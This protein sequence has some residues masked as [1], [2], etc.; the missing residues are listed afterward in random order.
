MDSEVEGRGRQSSAVEGMPRRIIRG[1]YVVTDPSGLPARGMVEDAGVL[2]A[3]DKVEEVAEWRALR[4]RCPDVEVFGSERHLVLPG[5]VNA[6]HHGRGLSG[7]QLGIPDDFLERWLLDYW[8]MPPLDVHLDT[9]YSNL[10]MIRSGVT[11]VIHSSYAR[12]WGRIEA[13]TRDAL[14]AYAEAGIRVA[15]AVGFEDRVRLVFGDQAAF[16]ASLPGDLAVRARELVQPVSETETE[17]YFAFVS[18]LHEQHSAN[19]ALEILHG[20]SWHVWCSRDLLERVAEDARNRN[21]GIHLHVLESPLEREY[22]LRAYGMDCVSYLKALGIRGPRVSFA[23]G[24]WL[25]ESEIEQCAESGVSICH[26]PS[27]NLRLRNGI[28]PV[29][30]MTECGV[31]V[32]IGMDSWGVSSNDD[33]LEELRLAGLLH[34]LPSRQRFESCPDAFDL[35]RMLTVN[36]A[37]AAT[38][39][40]GLGRLLPGSPADA[41]I[42]DFDRI[43]GPYL[44]DSVHPVEAFVHLARTQ[45]I[46]TVIAAGEPLLHEGHFTRVDEAAV[47]REIAAA[48]ASPN[49]AFRSF[50]RTL[51]ELR[52]HLERHYEGWP[53]GR[54]GEPFYVVNER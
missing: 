20:P 47:G 40:D 13:E 14:R 44:D 52:P 16:L 11:T 28:A 19:P 54:P 37:R 26:N 32:G 34:R 31:N 35:L 5:F 3:G 48:A 36:G 23:H 22:A 50:S 27:S 51:R 42:L 15:Y 39:G 2:I 17:R 29:A 9:L 25:S 45:H 24:T 1:R 41:V 8:R 49:P 12:E 46:D 43:A 18:E 10:K 4:E 6:H 33:I 53:A 21:L 38:F 30:R 7:I